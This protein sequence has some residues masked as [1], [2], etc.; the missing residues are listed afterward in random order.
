MSRRTIR[1]TAL[2]FA[3]LLGALAIFSPAA[4]A[5]GPPIVTLSGVSEIGLNTATLKGSVNANGGAALTYKVE[6]GKTKL[7]GHTGRTVASGESF[8]SGLIGLEPMTTYHYR[9]T[10]T[11]TL[12]TTVTEDGLFEVLRSWKV[13]GT[14]VEDL[15]SPVLFEQPKQGKEPEGGYI[16]LQGQ[17]LG[18]YTRVYCHQVN[19]VTGVLEVAG[20]RF[21]FGKCFTQLNGVTSSVC[22]PKGTVT[23]SLTS[24]LAEIGSTT[25]KSN[26]ECAVGESLKLTEAGLS[27]ETLGPEAVEQKNFSLYGQA[28]VNKQLFNVDLAIGTFSSPGGWKLTPE[29]TFEGLKFGIS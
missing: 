8:E 7:Y 24:N 1:R 25:F 28:L 4:L 19:H 2:L 17:L 20:P 10:A 6:Y 27:P 13:E 9:V 21:E 14:R 3:S 16:E 11:T 29:S 26:E 15:N 5:S 23:V 22:A 12:G 18:I